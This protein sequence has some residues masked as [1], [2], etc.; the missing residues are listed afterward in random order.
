LTNQ[1]LYLIIAIPTIFALVGIATNITLYALLA[2]RLDRSVESLR[3]EARADRK[4]L[5][6]KM[7]KLGASITADL[8][9]FFKTITELESRTNRLEERK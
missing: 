3:I 1:Q 7:D 4:E 5:T 6:E 9:E 8:K 2:G